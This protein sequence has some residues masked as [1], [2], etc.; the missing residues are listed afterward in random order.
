MIKTGQTRAQLP[1]RP[2]TSAAGQI[3]QARARV[4]IST[5]PASQASAETDTLGGG[6]CSSLFA[7]WYN[8]VHLFC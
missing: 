7:V 5:V 3:S 8:M 4:T 2:A 6:D 1:V